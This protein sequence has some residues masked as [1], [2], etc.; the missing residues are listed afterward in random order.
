MTKSSPTLIERL[1]KLWP[2]CGILMVFLAWASASGQQ[3]RIATFNIRNGME[4]P[5]TAEYR[6]SRR[7]LERIRP[8]VIAL[9]ELQKKNMPNLKRMLDGLNCP[10]LAVSDNGPL[11][12]NLSNGLASRYPL[13]SI[14]NIRSPDGALEMS[15]YPLAAVVDLPKTE[16]DPLVVCVHLK[17]SF[18]ADSEFRRAIELRRTLEY[19]RVAGGNGRPVFLLGDF[20]DDFSRRQTAVF[21]ERPT[22]LPR[23]YRLGDDIQL[24]LRYAPFPQQQMKQAGFSMV[25]TVQRNGSAQT[26]PGN[27]HR[28]DYIF[29]NEEVSRRGSISGEIYNSRLDR[30]PGGLP[31]YGT[32]PGDS[33]SEEASDH[34]V[35][36]ADYHYRTGD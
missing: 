5:D 31:K 35:V 18:Y 20:N 21:Y 13:R 34:L 22:R 14:A 10:H 11:S 19:I 36:F 7:I 4:G 3:L 30:L 12:G 16:H 29:Y 1:R 26:F 23:T 8:Q 28:I 6:A 25:R 15:R 33:A 32:W 9:Q 27:G 2:V 24:P 17:S